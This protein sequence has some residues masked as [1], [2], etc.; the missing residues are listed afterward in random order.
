MTPYP[1]NRVSFPTW[2]HQGK[3]FFTKTSTLCE[4][5]YPWFFVYLCPY[6]MFLYPFDAV[7]LAYL[8]LNRLSFFALSSLSSSKTIIC[9]TYIFSQSNPQ[10][11]TF[12]IMLPDF[13]DYVTTT[14]GNSLR[15]KIK[16]CLFLL[17]HRLLITFFFSSDSLSLTASYNLFFS[18]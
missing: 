6:Q 15:L 13:R 7:H 5:S 8:S 3:A 11:F 16:S 9:F 18:R 17:F 4:T 14:S 12:T 10:E 2:D 1:L